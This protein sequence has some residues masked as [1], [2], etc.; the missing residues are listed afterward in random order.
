MRGGNHIHQI[1]RNGGWVTDHEPKKEVIHDHFYSSIG[2]GLPRNHDLG[3]ANLNIGNV[4][5]EGIDDLFKEEE[6]QLAI[7]QMSSNKAPSPDGFIGAFFK[8]CWT[9]IKDDVMGA[10]LEFNN[11]HVVHHQWVNL[12]N[13]V[14]LPKKKDVEEINEYRLVRLIHAIAKI[15]AKMT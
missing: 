12:A 7:N 5:L 11:L 6:V 3:W 13:I 9:I 4:A 15:I 8:K 2:K 1:K 14:L 10:I